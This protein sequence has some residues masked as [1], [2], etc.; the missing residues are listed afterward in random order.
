MCEANTHLDS[1]EIYDLNLHTLDASMPEPLRAAILLEYQ[2]TPLQRY[3]NL[4][5]LVLYKEASAIERSY[6]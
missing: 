2:K 5:F 3:V 1:N 6:L 4:P